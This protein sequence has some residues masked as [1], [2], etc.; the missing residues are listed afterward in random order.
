MARSAFGAGTA[1]WRATLT[2]LDDHYVDVDGDSYG[3]DADDI[4]CCSNRRDHD[5]DK[6]LCWDTSAKG[7]YGVPPMQF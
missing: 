6:L 2:S 3:C 4:N 5:V 1:D 7:K